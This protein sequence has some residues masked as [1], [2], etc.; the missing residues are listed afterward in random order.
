MCTSAKILRL[1][2]TPTIPSGSC[3]SCNM[4]IGQGARITHSCE[5]CTYDMCEVCYKA[6]TS[7]APAP[8]RNAREVSPSPH[9]R[10]RNVRFADDS[11]TTGAAAAALYMPQ[12]RSM[13]CCGEGTLSA[14]LHQTR[15]GFTCRLGDKMSQRSVHEEG[16][17]SQHVEEA[18]GASRRRRA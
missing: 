10:P 9:G 2:L 12:E 4:T 14:V 8:T 16:R 6:K 11:P 1:S 13:C 5:T 3:D 17:T 15:G 18:V 7:A